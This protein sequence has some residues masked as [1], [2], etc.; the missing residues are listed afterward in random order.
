LGYVEGRDYVIHAR[1]ADTDQTRLPVLAKEL[2]GDGV[3][4]IVTFGTAAVRAAKEATSTIPIVMAGGND[5]I[6]NGFIAS[7]ARPGGNVT[8]VT[9]TPMGSAFHGKGLQLLK[10]VVPKL[11]RVAILGTLGTLPGMAA[12]AEELGITLL[13]HDMSDVKSTGDFQ[14][15]LSK[16]LEERVDAV[17]VPGNFVNDKYRREVLDFIAK[18]RLPSMFEETWWVELQSGLLSYFTDI[19]DL[20]R[21][22]AFFVDKILKGAKSADL[23]VEQPTRFRLV[24]NLKTANALGLTVPHSI[25]QRADVVIE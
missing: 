7:L 19:G 9:R 13:E 17:Y 6:G 21:R 16:I 11:S 4:A 5:P 1:Y 2:I 8:G 20:R 22:A 18:N 25:L 3:D 23:P 14:A 15:I 10:E 24:I 12:A